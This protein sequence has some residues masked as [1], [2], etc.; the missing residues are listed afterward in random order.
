MA[1]FATV[2]ILFAIVVAGYAVA[3]YARSVND[4]LLEARARCDRAWANVE[5]LLE[6]RYDEVGTL[7]DVAAEHMEYERELLEELLEARERAIEAQDPSTAAEASVEI[8]E[9]VSELYTL[10]EE[11]PSLRAADRFDDVRDA[12][13]EVEQRL[14]NRREYYNDAVTTYNARIRGIP[15]RFF[16]EIHG[17]E[18]R[19]PFWAS[20][21][22]RDGI[23]VRERLHRDAD[24]H[25]SPAE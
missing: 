1:L 3:R 22:A 8:K 14:E 6:R 25:S 16:A 20:D 10:S 19:S 18:P 23:D 24:G 12:M 11:Y 4:D 21:A 2:V 5:V 13:Q 15:E 17:M 9:A 7:V